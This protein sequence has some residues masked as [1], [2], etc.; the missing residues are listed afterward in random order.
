MAA[1]TTVT[2]PICTYTHMHQARLTCYFHINCYLINQEDHPIWQLVQEGA[3][4]W[5]VP[6]GSELPVYLPYIQHSGC[7]LHV[8]HIKVVHISIQAI[9]SAF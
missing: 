6:C 7:F 8:I 4:T 5:S 1:L 2:P 9:N 3:G